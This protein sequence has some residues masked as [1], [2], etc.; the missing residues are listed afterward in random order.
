[1]LQAEA[2]NARY[3]MAAWFHRKWLRTPMKL[4][5]PL[6]ST[7]SNLCSPHSSSHRYSQVQCKLLRPLLPRASAV[8]VGG[9]ICSQFYSPKK[10]KS[11]GGITLSTWM[12]NNVPKNV[13]AEAKKYH[14]ALM[15]ALPC[16]PVG[17][18]P[19]QR[20]SPGNA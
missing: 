13:K 16:V 18:G 9:I 2:S 10:Y 6:P 17:M 5:D 8:N 12:S 20:A 11:C 14:R 1:V 3:T 19:L 15:R 7:T 4:Q